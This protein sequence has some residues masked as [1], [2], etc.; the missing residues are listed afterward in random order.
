MIDRGRS[1]GA[2]SL[3]CFYK[4]GERYQS[5]SGVLRVLKIRKIEA[6]KVTKREGHLETSKSFAYFY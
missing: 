5:V 6:L 2:L 1:C 3:F 4:I